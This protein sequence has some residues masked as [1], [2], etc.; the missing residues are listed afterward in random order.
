MYVNQPVIQEKR[1]ETTWRRPFLQFRDNRPLNVWQENIVRQCKAIIAEDPGTIKDIVLEEH[2]YK[3]QGEAKTIEALAGL[4]L[5]Y[6]EQ[7]LK[8]FLKTAPVRKNDDFY[9]VF[10]QDDAD[11]PDK[12]YWIGYQLED[13]HAKV[14][15][16]GP[17]G[18][19]TT[20]QL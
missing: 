9:D 19:Q 12:A 6:D 4:G 2:A 10:L 15:H 7:K 5:D 17:F 16:I 3:H 1:Q 18:I 13:E 20:A 11:N 14:K 8:D